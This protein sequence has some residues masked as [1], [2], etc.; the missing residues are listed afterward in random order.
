MVKRKVTVVWELLQIKKE[1]AFALEHLSDNDVLDLFSTSSAVI[2]ALEQDDPP[3]RLVDG[4]TL[5]MWQILNDGVPRYL[6]TAAV[7][8]TPLICSECAKNNGSRLN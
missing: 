6:A 3:F 1:E 2:A 4:D 8:V 5:E 7:N